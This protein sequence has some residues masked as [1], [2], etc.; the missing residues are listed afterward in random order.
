VGA[1]AV[2]LPLNLGRARRRGILCRRERLDIDYIGGG[3]DAGRLASARR[4]IINGYNSGAWNGRGHLPR[5]A[6]ANPSNRS[7]GYA[8]ASGCDGRERGTFMGREGGSVA[9]SI[10]SGN[11]RG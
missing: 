3:N 11:G 6:A 1:N 5:P 4:Q 7:V 2:A 10:L 8:L 9:S